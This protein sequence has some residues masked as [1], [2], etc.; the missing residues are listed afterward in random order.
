[1]PRSPHPLAISPL[2]PRFSASDSCDQ[3]L[4]EGKRGEFRGIGPS[5]GIYVV[6]DGDPEGHLAWRR[7]WM[8]RY[9]RGCGRK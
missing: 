4:E 8:P 9:E 2:F 1:M 6:V 7:R 5:S 3:H